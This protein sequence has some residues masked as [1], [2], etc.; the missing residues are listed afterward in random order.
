M[1][2]FSPQ[3][4]TFL[5]FYTPPHPSYILDLFPNFLEDIGVEYNKSFGSTL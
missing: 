4:L 1:I 5:P 2:P 3:E